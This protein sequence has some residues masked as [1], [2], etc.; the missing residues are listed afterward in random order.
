M[1]YTGGQHPVYCNETAKHM[2]PFLTTDKMTSMAL[3]SMSCA[4]VPP[5]LC[6]SRAAEMKDELVERVWLRLCLL[7][8]LL[9][10][11]HGL[12]HIADG[13]RGAGGGVG[14]RKPFID[15]LSLFIIPFP[16]YIFPSFLTFPSVPLTLH[17][18]QPFL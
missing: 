14:P 15:C 7:L 17:L 12:L 6:E 16:L 9:L 13:G 5:L 8:F 2:K 4:R 11:L 18:T 1:T 3:T 10:L